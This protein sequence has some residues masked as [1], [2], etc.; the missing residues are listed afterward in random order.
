MTGSWPAAVFDAIHA[1]GAD[2]WSVESSPYEREKYDQT[3]AALPA[4]RFATAL[5]IGCSIGAQTIRLA[6]RADRLLAVDIAAE[7][8][9]RTRARCAHLPH[10][11]IRQAQIPRD[12]PEGQFDLIVISE[13]L[14]FLTPEDIATTARLAQARAIVLVNWTGFTDTPTTGQQ[15]AE[16][17]K[18]NSD[19]QQT[20][21]AKHESYRI[22][23]LQRKEGLLF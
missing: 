6:E 22:D 13:V 10:V 18:A 1:R 2:P 11:D 17:F 23:V 3:L 20:H 21:S 16:L 4:P 5:E 8:V 12:W 7:P 9:R 14:Y 19:L 15:A